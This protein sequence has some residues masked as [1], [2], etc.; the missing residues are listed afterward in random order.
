MITT[1]KNEYLDDAATNHY[2]YAA[3]FD[4]TGTEIT[5]G[6]PAYARKAIT[7]GAA[8]NGEISA[9]NVPI[10][11]DVPSGATVASVRLFDQLTGGTDYS[12]AIAFTAETFSN[13]G[14]FKLNTL[15]E[16]MNK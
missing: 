3:L 6:S 15:S 14:V 12:G 11:F 7:F 5:G 8:S 13:Q 16:N 1:L 9:T 4:N 10:E 2:K